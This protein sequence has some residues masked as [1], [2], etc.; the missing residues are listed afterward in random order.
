[1]DAVDLD[2]LEKALREMIAWRDFLADEM[3]QFDSEIAGAARLWANAQG[4]TV[5][6]NLAQLR[7]DLGVIDKRAPVP[8]TDE[9]QSES[10]HG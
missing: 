6:P 9:S 4:I 1:M 10:A 2:R 8:L 5:K 3:R 7:R